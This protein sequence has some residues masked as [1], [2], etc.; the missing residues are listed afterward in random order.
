VARKQDEG[1]ILARVIDAPVPAWKLRCSA[2]TSCDLETPLK[3]LFR[4]RASSS[5]TWRAL[6]TVLTKMTTRNHTMNMALTS[7]M[8]GELLIRSFSLGAAVSLIILLLAAL[9]SSPI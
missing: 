4:A 3:K 8:L 5:G 9:F 7:A 6:C 2:H 1:F